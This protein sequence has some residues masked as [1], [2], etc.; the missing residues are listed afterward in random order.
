ML[1]KLSFLRKQESKK[2]DSRLHGNDS[3]SDN[4][5]GTPSIRENGGS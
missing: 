5:L 2:G 4:G 3:P 1:D